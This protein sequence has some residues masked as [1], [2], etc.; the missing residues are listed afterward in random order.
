[1]IDGLLPL[2]YKEVTAK[3]G[4]LGRLLLFCH[5]C[6]NQTGKRKQYNAE[7]KQSVICNN[8]HIYHPLSTQG[9][10]ARRFTPCKK[11]GTNRLSLLATPGSKRNH[12]YSTKHLHISQ[13]IFSTFPAK[14]LD[15]CI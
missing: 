5:D 13:N 4:N 10:G 12:T 7:L 6:D 14:R 8:I 11:R 3:L 1:M 9:Q 15:F 2:C